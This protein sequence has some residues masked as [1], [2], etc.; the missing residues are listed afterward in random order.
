LGR[1]RSRREVHH[2]NKWEGNVFQKFGIAR[3]TAAWIIISIGISVAHAQILLE[4]RGTTYRTQSDFHAPLSQVVVGDKDVSIGGFGVYGQT[5]VETNVRWVIFDSASPRVPVFL[6]DVYALAPE[7]GSFASSARWHDSP[8]VDFTLVANRRYAMGILADRLGTTGFRWGTSVTSK[9]YGGGG[10]SIEAEGLSVPFAAALANAGLGGS[11]YSTPFVY[12]Y[13]GPDPLEWNA[14]LQPS[15]RIASPV[16]E[17]AEW[18][19]LLSGLMAIGWV[20]RRRR[21]RTP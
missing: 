15:L 11:F 17:P 5:S 13:A 4:H 14:A 10:A 3:A 20:S 16:A 1:A 18:A 7:P 8:V 12:T 19:M 2:Q 9:R 21:R 6:S